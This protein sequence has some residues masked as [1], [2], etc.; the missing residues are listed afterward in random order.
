MEIVIGTL[1]WSLRCTG[2]HLS[3]VKMWWSRV[4]G[5]HFP[6]MSCLTGACLLRRCRQA[7]LELNDVT[8]D[9]GSDSTAWLVGGAAGTYAVGTS[10]GCEP[11]SNWGTLYGA[12]C[13][14]PKS[15][16]WR[17]WIGFCNLGMLL[18]WPGPLKTWSPKALSVVPVGTWMTR[19][20][21]WLMTWRRCVH[22]L[23]F[24]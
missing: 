16:P 15:P 18:A 24:H 22:L 9:I 17:S 7:L 11:Y 14:S 5:A 13:S 6:T 10:C 23:V 2:V 4:N 19:L 20:Q 21:T 1:G 3:L 12:W 8:W